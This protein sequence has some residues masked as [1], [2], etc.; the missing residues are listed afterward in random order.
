[1]AKARKGRIINIASVVGVLG[2]AGQVNYTAAKAGVI[3]TTHASI[4]QVYST[5]EP[6]YTLLLPPARPVEHP[7]AERT[8]P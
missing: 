7:I 3:G 2:N 6:R 5:H 1:M 4:F 8:N